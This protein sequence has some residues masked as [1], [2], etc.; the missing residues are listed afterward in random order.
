MIGL[1]LILGGAAFAAGLVGAL[2]LLTSRTPATSTDTITV[3]VLL[4]VG[5]ILQLVGVGLM[6]VDAI[7]RQGNPK[8]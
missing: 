1:M 5:V 8:K 6:I 7:E 3:G 4:A 2:N